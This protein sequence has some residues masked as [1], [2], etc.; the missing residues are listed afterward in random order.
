MPKDQTADAVA[1]SARMKPAP[2]GPEV[3]LVMTFPPG[4]LEQLRYLLANG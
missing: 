2:W 4:E 3:I 1:V